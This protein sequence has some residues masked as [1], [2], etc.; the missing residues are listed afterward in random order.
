MG[1]RVS[2]PQI[3][4]ELRH[5]FSIS[6]FCLELIE[7]CAF[8][9]PVQCFQGKHLAAGRQQ[10]FF[11]I[12]ATDAETTAANASDDLIFVA[13]GRLSFRAKAA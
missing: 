1:Y 12:L 7:L 5:G 6:L 9:K 8:D 4:A 11:H 2:L 13:A 3:S 10:E